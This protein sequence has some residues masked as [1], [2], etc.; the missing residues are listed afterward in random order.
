M[1]EGMS[2]EN[3]DKKFAFKKSFS[4]KKSNLADCSNVDKKRLGEDL[5]MVCP[6]AKFEIG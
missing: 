1:F 3:F 2:P 4:I 5:L 6:E